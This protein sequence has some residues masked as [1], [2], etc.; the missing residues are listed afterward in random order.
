MTDVIRSG[1]A[2]K[3]ILC[4]EHTNY[5][6]SPTKNGA[7]NY[8]GIT[9]KTLPNLKLLK[10]FVCFVRYKLQQRVVHN[11]ESSTVKYKPESSPFNLSTRPKP[12]EPTAQF[13]QLFRHIKQ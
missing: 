5:G 7:L 8:N 9:R 11:V 12:F 2:R 10:S 6:R 4:K 1:F 3:L 13:E